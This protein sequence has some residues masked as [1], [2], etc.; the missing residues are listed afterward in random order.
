MDH[1]RVRLGACW[2]FSIAAHLLILF[3]AS[4]FVAKGWINTPL[5]TEPTPS[6]D[7]T[8]TLPE[9][10]SGASSA[11]IYTQGQVR[12]GQS[13]LRHRTLSD[14]QFEPRDADYLT[15]WRQHI[16]ST[17]TE[18]YKA[19]LKKSPAMKGSLTMRVTLDA[20]GALKN[21]I[22]EKSSGS[23]ALDKLALSI[24]QQAA[25]FKPLPDAMKKDTDTLDIL[26][27][28]DFNP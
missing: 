20:S 11:I 24:V 6:L 15:A 14:T 8:L 23:T 2:S 3:S 25:P 22:I 10:T 4:I 17:G 26:R 13:V 5:L 16:E 1:A 18:R 9:D 12:T 28:W 19:A 21:V 7:V 27:T